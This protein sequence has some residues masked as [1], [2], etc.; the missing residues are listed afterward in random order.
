MKFDVS[1]EVRRD[2][3]R[4]KLLQ[5]TR[6]AFKMLPEIRDPVIL[7]IGCGTGVATLEL[8]RL[9]AGRV[10]GVDVDQVALDSLNQKIEHAGLTS[11]V[12]TVNGSM[13]DMQFR[14]NSFDIIWC[15]GAIY[16]VGFEEGLRA[17]R[18]FL[19]HKGFLVVHARIVDVEKRIDSVS[20]CGYDLLN[21]FRVSKESWWD[22]Y[23]GPMENLIE[24]LRHRYQNYPDAL[25]LLTKVQKEVDEFKSNPQ[26]HGSV[27]Y[28]MQRKEV[29]NT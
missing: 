4:S 2:Y 29:S 27:F 26:H 12:K 17:W 13:M 8:A 23:Y 6:K 14:D 7:D 9:S 25:A 20:S 19:R 15:E 28:V 1:A 3:F 21:T 11:R 24:G 16:V 18:R 22:D 10:V 5:Y